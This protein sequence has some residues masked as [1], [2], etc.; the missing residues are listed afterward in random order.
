[1]CGRRQGFELG[2]SLTPRHRRG[3]LASVTQEDAA[4]ICPTREHS[5]TS[6]SFFSFFVLPATLVV[7]P[8]TAEKNCLTLNPSSLSPQKGCSS[9]GI[10]ASIGLLGYWPKV[11]RLVYP[12]EAFYT[13]SPTNE[14][15]PNLLFLL[16]LP[17]DNAQHELQR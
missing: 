6:A 17:S 12:N 11:N 16:C 13:N 15:H 2:L 14:K 3:N 8:Y 4:F 9:Y 1:M 10:K 5:G 7:N